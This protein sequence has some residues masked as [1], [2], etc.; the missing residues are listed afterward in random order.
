MT[1]RRVQVWFQNKRAKERR[2]IKMMVTEEQQQ[3][4]NP[5]NNLTQKE[6][7]SVGEIGLGKAFHAPLIQSPSNSPRLG[8]AQEK[9]TGINQQ[10][11]DT[12]PLQL[13]DDPPQ[14][15]SNMHFSFLLNNIQPL[16]RYK[17]EWKLPPL[18]EIYN[19]ILK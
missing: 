15:Q 6:R 5:S 19:G 13:G 8:K 16:V 17:D 18:K 12:P 1:P 2:V 3:L 11:L 10:P 4:N 7:I 9:R 14:Q